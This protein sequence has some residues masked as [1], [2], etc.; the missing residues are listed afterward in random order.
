MPLLLDIS[1]DRCVFGVAV[2]GAYARIARITFDDAT[3]MVEVAV[4]I[5]V[6][7]QARNQ[8]RAP[9]AGGV[10]SGILGASGPASL[11]RGVIYTWLK[12]LPDF[13]TAVDS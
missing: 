12:T 4:N 13:A 3:D 5:W 9:I 1:E 6:N 11:A 7:L 10:Y 2:T 8:G